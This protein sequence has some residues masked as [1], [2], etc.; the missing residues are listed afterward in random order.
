MG[1]DRVWK[2]PERFRPYLGAKIPLLQKDGGCVAGWLDVQS[3]ELSLGMRCTARTNSIQHVPEVC[4][5][6]FM[7]WGPKT[8]ELPRTG[9]LA[10]RRCGF[11]AARAPKTSAQRRVRPRR[12][13]P[14]RE[15]TCRFRIVLGSKLIRV[16][17][18]VTALVRSPS[19]AGPVVMMRPPSGPWLSHTWPVCCLPSN[20]GSAGLVEPTLDV[21]L[22]TCWDRGWMHIWD[23]S[24]LDNSRTPNH[25]VTAVSLTSHWAVVLWISACGLSARRPT[26]WIRPRKGGCYIDTARRDAKTY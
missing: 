12:E 18:S 9:G 22:A 10:Q 7:Q 17:I 20:I 24:S 13:P 14:K 2:Y 1:D 19:L 5:S 3:Q 26:A 16:P 15:Q 8:Y 23:S 21:R 6:R 25:G 11:P 4:Q